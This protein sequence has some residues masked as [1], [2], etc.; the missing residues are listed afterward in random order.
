MAG[1]SGTITATGAVGTSAVTHAS[2]KMDFGSGSVDVEEQM[3][4]GSWVKIVTAITADYR[5]VYD[6]PTLAT[7]RL[8]CTSFTSNINYIIESN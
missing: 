8:N 5:Y 1:A 4:D 6:S 2:I 7:I 3:P